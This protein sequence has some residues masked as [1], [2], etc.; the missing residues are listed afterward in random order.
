LKKDH[1]SVLW[2]NFILHYAGISDIG[3]KR[4]KNEDDFLVLPEKKLFCVADGAGGHDAG[5]L[6]SRLTLSGIVSVI[7]KENS[8]INKAFPWRHK[9]GSNSKP[10]LVNAIEFANR[11]VF[12]ASASHNMAS[13]I[14][15][16][17]FQDNS[18]HICHVGD[19][20]A[21]LKRSN[22]LYQITEDHSLVYAL[23]KSGQIAEEEIQTHPHR[24]IITRAIGPN[25]DIQV[26]YQLIV[27]KQ[28][29][30]ILMCSD[31]LSSMITD[32]MILTILDENISI[33][34]KSE[35]LVLK[36]NQA[37]GHDN[38]TVLLMQIFNRVF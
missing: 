33:L 22:N 25:K 38:I 32:E 13:T 34:E 3:R 29:D 18:L 15:A 26:G 37:G 2:Q 19:S 11:K 31:G 30:V 23:Y 1:G 28:D 8:K 4:Q 36:A 12:Q 10:L 35:K 21:Y 6:A 14:V 16:C 5:V 20:R 7:S 9:Q 24:N 17:H 27:P